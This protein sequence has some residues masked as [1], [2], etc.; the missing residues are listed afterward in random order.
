MHLKFTVPL[1]LGTK[2]TEIT[3]VGESTDDPA[4]ETLTMVN[5]TQ[6]TELFPITEVPVYFNVDHIKLSPSLTHST[7]T[8]MIIIHNCYEHDVIAYNWKRLKIIDYEN[9]RSIRFLTF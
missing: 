9:I 8:N 1:L 4:C 7:I 5:S 2:K 6:F 3:I